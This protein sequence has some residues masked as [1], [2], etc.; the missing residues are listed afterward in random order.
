MLKK[1]NRCPAQIKQRH[2]PCQNLQDVSFMPI[3]TIAV[4]QTLENG[5][6][7]FEDEEVLKE[8]FVI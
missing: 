5:N 6:L 1:E 8:K 2:P 3:F 7:S 4:L